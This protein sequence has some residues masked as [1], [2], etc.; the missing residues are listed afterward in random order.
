V[1]TAIGLAPGVAARSLR[2][3]LGRFTSDEDVEAAAARL[4]AAA[5][6]REQDQGSAAERSAAE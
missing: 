3:G 4:A 5:C 6:H 2:I 1:L